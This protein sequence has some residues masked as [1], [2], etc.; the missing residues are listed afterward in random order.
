MGRPVWVRARSGERRGRTVRG[1]WS[2]A[3]RARPGRRRTPARDGRWRCPDA[4]A[5]L[6]REPLRPVSRSRVVHVVNGPTPVDTPTGPAPTCMRAIRG[7]TPARIPRGVIATRSIGAT[8]KAN[9]MP[10]LW[11]DYAIGMAE[12]LRSRCQCTDADLCDAHSEIRIGGSDG[13]HGST[14]FDGGEHRA[15]TFAQLENHRIA[16]C[17][18]H[19]DPHVG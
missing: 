2:A 12:E 5:E 14:A 1:G 11:Q 18:S 13:H 4:L 16:I 10:P 9:P 15:G 8:R 3:H 7:P 6:E 19:L 17:E